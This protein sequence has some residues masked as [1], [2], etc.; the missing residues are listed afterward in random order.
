MIFLIGGI[1]CSGKST[2]TRN[3]I[4]RLSDPVDI[5]PMPLFK[6]QEHG[7][8]LVVGRYPEG[9]TFGGTD[10]LSHGSIPH[11]RKFVDEITPRYKHTIIE[12]DRYFRNDDIEWLLDNHEAEVYILTVDLETEKE[13]HQSRGDTQSEVWLQGRRTQIDNIRKNFNL[14]GRLIIHENYSIQ[15]SMKLED[16][17]YGKIVR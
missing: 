6:C 2:L 4:S 16:Y 14:M 17:I 8:I 15:Q 3:L 9:E 1:P 10:K 13:R 7:D 11:F 12:G 5:E